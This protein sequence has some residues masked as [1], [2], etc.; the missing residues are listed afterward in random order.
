[1]KFI[2]RYL[3]AIGT[4]LA[5]TQSYAEEL[6]FDSLALEGGGSKSISYVGALLAFKEMG[7][8]KEGLYKFNTIGGT[9]AGCFVSFL[10]SLDV[11]PAALE[12]LVYKMDIFQSSINF[13]VDLFDT[14]NAPEKSSSHTWFN[15]I[16]KTFALIT[17]ARDIVDLWLDYDSPGLSTEEMFL[18]FLNDIIV[19]LSPHKAFIPDI[20]R[21]T[22]YDLAEIT[23][24]NLR[25][26]A[27]QLNDKILYEFSVKRTPNE[28]VVKAI[29]ASMAL[30]GLFKPLND[31]YGNTLVDGGLLYNFP[32][33]M[34]DRGNDIDKRTLGLS[35]N[36]KNDAGQ[37]VI[38]KD[39]N[40]SISGSK[41]AFT[42]LNTLEYIEAIYS[43]FT[44][45]E[46]HLYSNDPINN[47]RIIYLESPI[48][49][50]NLNIV[51][52][53]KSLAINKAY[54]NTISFLQ[55]RS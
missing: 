22:F 13:N 1:M 29:Y 11:S 31:G 46:L 7:Y 50:L 19:P 2:V 32:I 37:S 52:S 4:A 48:K 49:T 24:H 16:M 23:N 21:L 44:E 27:T 54:L 41:F 34:N 5:T 3:L 33:T 36:K 45:K 20:T 55:H 42:K 6:K 10:I 43:V 30:P 12:E 25:C 40:V 38:H 26:F 9:S 47:D 35:L 15:T 8:Y 39:P 18:R 14:N 28:H 53:L 51:D 17:K